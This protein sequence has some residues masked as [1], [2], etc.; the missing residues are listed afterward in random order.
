MTNPSNALVLVG[1][2]AM[3]QAK[4][5]ALFPRLRSISISA[6]GSSPSYSRGQRHGRSM[7]VHRGSIGGS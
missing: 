5:K 4:T 7:G 6:C 1:R 3:V 2:D